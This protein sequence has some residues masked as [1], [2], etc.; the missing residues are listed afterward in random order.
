MPNN[1]SG[2]IILVTGA[3]SGIGKATAKH[4]A[5]DGARVAIMAR[6]IAKLESLRAECPI[7]DN[8][9]VIGGD[10]SVEADCKRCIQ[11]IVAKW[12][13]LDAVIHN[14]GVSMRG[15][16][17][18]TE[19]QVFQ[20]LM[21]VNYYSLVYMYKHS[22]SSLRDRRG[23]FVSVSSMM[24]KYST[25]LRAGYTASKHAMVGFMDSVRL[26]LSEAGVHV[27]TVIPG[28]VNT[29]VAQNAFA[30]SGNRHGVHDQAILAGLPPERVAQDIYNGMKSRKREAVSSH[31]KER[32]ALFLSK[33]SPSLLDRLLLK[34]KVT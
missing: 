5:E 8:V 25:Q 6:T 18:E 13:G 1:F 9:L 17:E 27:M 33:W 26:E 34:I 23:H 12:G 11:A 14:A 19:V 24:G 30:P 2:K 31:F 22:V 32:F 7:P 29:D 4:F 15:S 3:S 20:S 16:A 28:F 10:V 21:E